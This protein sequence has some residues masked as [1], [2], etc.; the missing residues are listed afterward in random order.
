MKKVAILISVVLIGGCGDTQ[1]AFVT[2]SDANHSLSVIREQ[3]YF[4]GSWKT[5][6]IVAGLPQCQRRYPMDEPADGQFRVAVHRP[7]PGTFILDSGA[8]WSVVALQD[9]AFQVYKVPP[10]FPGELVGNFEIKDGTLHYS[11]RAGAAGSSRG[12]AA[13]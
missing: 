6:L 10:P 1:T 7:A 2:E 5:T 12:T 11:A 4:H 3:A 13:R 9:C 8:Q